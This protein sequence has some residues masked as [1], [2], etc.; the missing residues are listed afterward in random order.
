M[1]CPVGIEAQAGGTFT[2]TAMVDAPAGHLLGPPERRPGEPDRHLRPSPPDRLRRGEPRRH[3]LS[4]RRRRRHRGLRPRRPHRPG[5]LPRRAHLLH[6]D[7][8]VRPGRRRTAERHGRRRRSRVLPVRLTV[9]TRAV[10]P[11][12]SRGN[13]SA[14]PSAPLG[15]GGGRSGE[16]RTSAPGE[17]G[18]T[19][20]TSGPLRSGH[21]PALP[22]LVHLQRQHLPLPDRR[23]G[24]RAGRSSRPGSPTA[25]GSPVPAPVPGTSGIPPTR[26][27]RRCWPSTATTTR[28]S[29]GRSTTSCSTRTCSSPSTRAT[30]V[31]YA[32]SPPIPNG[33]GSCASSTRTRRPGRG[34]PTRT[35]A[36]RRVSPRCSR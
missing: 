14:G 9:P 24:V 31:P 8:R 30:S 28:T 34:S 6:R 32:G 1:R 15:S 22:R 29:R 21:G 25:S 2:C 35:T 26:G 10:A 7:Q 11:L 3:G 17:P 13:H 18:R 4:G 36:G 20:C 33:S 27:P 16:V 23:E 19:F 12:G 5:Q